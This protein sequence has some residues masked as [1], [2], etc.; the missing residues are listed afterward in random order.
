MTVNPALKG[1]EPSHP[2]VARL[3]ATILPRSSP[4]LILSHAS[5]SPF[6]P[7]PLPPPHRCGVVE[8]ATPEMAQHAIASLN[9]RD[10]KGRMV[11]VREDR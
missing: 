10:L 2:A 1:T 5:P 7:P 6:S 8:Y 4:S 3:S 11:F 9:D